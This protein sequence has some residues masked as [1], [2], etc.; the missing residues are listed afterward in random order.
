MRSAIAQAMLTQGID[1]SPIQSPWQGAARLANALVGGS[2]AGDLRREEQARQKQIT[3]MLGSLPGLAGGTAPT[4]AA[5]AAPQSSL[6]PATPPAQV[7]VPA[8]MQPIINTASA[9]SGVPADRIAAVLKQESNFNP[10]AVSPKGATG[11]A[12]FMPATA[13]ERGVNPL[14]PNS[15][16]PGAANYLADLKKQF[17]GDDRLALMA[18]NWGPG[19]VQNWLK[20]GADP[21]KVPPET[22][23][24]LTKTMGG[25]Q[26]AQAGPSIDPQVAGTIRALISNP[27][28][29][30]Y[31]LQLYGQFAKPTQYGFQTLPDGTVVRTDPRSGTVTPIMSAPKNP[32]YGVISKDQYGNEQYGWIDPASRTTSPGQQTGTPSAVNVPAMP[33]G[34]APAAPQGL[35]APPPGADPKEWRKQQ[36]KLAVGA[37][38]ANSQRQK[39]ADIVTT[40]IDRV[41][42]LIDKNPNLTTGVGGAVMQ[43]IPGTDAFNASALADTIKANV[44]FD[45]LQEM[46]NASP[47][48]GALGQVSEMENKL[49]Q[50]TIGNLAL[51]QNK[52]QLRFNLKRVRDIY[53]R[54]INEGIS[55][56]QAKK[57][58][59][60]IG[61]AKGPQA[62]VVEDGYRFKGGDP[63][64]QENWERVQ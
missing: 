31:G 9:S 35:P 64:K 7:N 39:Y 24:Y 44:G 51:S 5:P 16:I 33:Q 38:A 53:G 47:T 63:S 40:D 6:Q 25:Q 46:R 15:A 41:L 10:N 18:Y 17:G 11:V 23:N 42:D 59:G 27:S 43:N 45:R 49:L 60:D 55:P 12:Q 8:N 28:T 4:D 30:A 32:T 19:N 13:Q 14:D 54:I 48:G 50:A 26:V 2:M 52:D 22:Q 29:R 21:S 58:L 3:D 57:E 36:T 20:G 34:E 1:T 37:Q 61:G 62:G 56:D